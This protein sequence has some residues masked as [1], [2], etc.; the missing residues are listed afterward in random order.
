MAWFERGTTRIYYE[1]H[2]SGHPVLL[3][4]GFAGSIEELSLLTQALASNHRVVAADLPGSGRSAPQ[5]RAYTPTFYEDDAQTFIEL[6]TDLGTGPA[7]LIGYSDGGEISL[8]MAGLK[9]GIARSVLTWGAMGFLET[10]QLPLLEAFESVVDNP[11]EPLRDFSDYLKSTYGQSNA[12][13]MTQNFANATR[14]II[15]GGGDI[16]RSR[17]TDIACPVLLIAGEDDF[18]APPALVSQFASAVRGAEV[19]PLEGAGHDVH[20]S[21]PEWLART[22]LSWLARH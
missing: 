11:I 20:A 1:E 5:P 4:P 14:A 6:L 22:V 19:L 16:A 7:H 13:T 17:A 9:P 15:Q 21:H 8:V 3:M 12:R 10:S 18:F 2:G